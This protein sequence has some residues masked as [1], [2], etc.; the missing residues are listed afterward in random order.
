MGHVSEIDLP[1]TH[2]LPQLAMEAPGEGGGEMQTHLAAATCHVP[3]PRATVSGHIRNQEP[4]AGN[5]GGGGGAKARGAQPR[6]SLSTS[7][8][9]KLQQRAAVCSWPSRPHSCPNGP[10]FPPPPMCSG[11][12]NSL[13]PLG[14]VTSPVTVIRGQQS[15]NLRRDRVVLQQKPLTVGGGPH[16][17]RESWGEGGSGGAG[18]RGRG[19]K[20]HTQRE[21]RRRA[22]SYRDADPTVG[23][24]GPGAHGHSRVRA[25]GIGSGKKG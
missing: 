18:Q 11:L 14:G 3:H 25:P 20:G 9:P 5:T 17:A 7:Q 12:P 4:L 23:R 19:R 8:Q 21:S 2:H 16:G 15:P 10:P 1:D 13:P 6:T 22:Q 24:G